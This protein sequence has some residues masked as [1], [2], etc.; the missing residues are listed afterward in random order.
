MQ[1]PKAFLRLTDDSLKG[2]CLKILPGVEVGSCVVLDPVQKSSP[3]HMP[4]E[5]VQVS[6][7]P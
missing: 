2:T 7:T 4:L 5:L 6:H 3:S 1:A